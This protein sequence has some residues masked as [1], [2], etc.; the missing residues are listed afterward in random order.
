ML[1]GRTRCEGDTPVAVAM[2]HIQDTPQPPSHLNPNIPP[3]LEEIILR[4][5]E[6]IPEMRYRDGNTLARALEV[7]GEET[8]G[9]AHGGPSALQ[10]PPLNGFSTTGPT[11]PPRPTS[12]PSHRL[13][14]AQ[15]PA[16]NVGMRV[17]G[18]PGGATVLP[19]GP[20]AG[21]APVP[22]D[23]DATTQIEQQQGGYG[24]PPNVETAETRPFRKGDLGSDRESRIA[25]I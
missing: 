10:A 14:P 2:Q 13:A 20:A 17:G 1:T 8:V 16:E 9:F 4:C 7:L 3:A 21:F 22:I 23:Q 24:P 6:K 25:G 15:N 12:S 5:L 18:G 19:P 11:V